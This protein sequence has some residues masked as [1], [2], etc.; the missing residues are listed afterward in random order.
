MFEQMYE[1]EGPFRLKQ[2]L[3]DLENATL[4]GAQLGCFMAHRPKQVNDDDQDT[5]SEEEMSDGG[6][7]IPAKHKVSK[8][9]SNTDRLHYESLARIMSAG[10]GS[11]GREGGSSGT[12]QP[13]S[14]SAAHAGKTALPTRPRH[15][16][17]RVISR[18]ELTPKYIEQLRAST[19]RHGLSIRIPEGE[20][21]NA[22]LPGDAG[23][24]RPLASVAPKSD[25]DAAKAPVTQ[26]TPIS[27]PRIETLQEL[28]QRASTQ[29][30]CTQA[31][32]PPQV[33][34]SPP[35][36]EQERRPDIVGP[37]EPAPSPRGRRV[38]P[39]PEWVSI[40]DEDFLRAVSDGEE[41]A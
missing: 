23:R 26:K 18:S 13:H 41:C 19:N 4:R 38:S 15:W 25:P 16:V 33:E 10:P 6:C 17:E 9:P 40:D 1:E 32:A 2:A 12:P 24:E 31:P 28:H 11:Q 20:Q 8:P 39:D 29:L 22:P 21:Q 30:S 37:S 36:K 3:I 35:A 27:L 5:E 14:S 7:L 34:A